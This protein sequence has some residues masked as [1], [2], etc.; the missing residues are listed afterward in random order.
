MHVIEQQRPQATPIPGVEHATW[1]GRADGLSQLSLWRQTLAPSAATPPHGHDCDEVVLCIA[2]EGEV[3]SEGRVQRFGAD[4]TVV[5]P[6]GR[7]HQIFNVGSVP[8]EILGIFAATPVATQLPDG[9]ALELPWR[10]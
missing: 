9:Q 5:L 8:L 4:T 6:R 7:L 2:G 1:A 10:S 3:H